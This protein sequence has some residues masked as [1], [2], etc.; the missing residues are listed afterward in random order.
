V[1]RLTAAQLAVLVD[2]MDWSR[3][4]GRD[5]AQPTATS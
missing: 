2:G 5:I 3:L 1:M 4:H